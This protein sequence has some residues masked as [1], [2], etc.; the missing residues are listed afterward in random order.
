MRMVRGRLKTFLL[1]GVGNSIESFRRARSDCAVRRPVVVGT[2]G[3]IAGEEVQVVLKR[4]IAEVLD[5][6]V[7]ILHG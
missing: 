3:V 1:L 4:P 6:D 7:R 5:S 2:C